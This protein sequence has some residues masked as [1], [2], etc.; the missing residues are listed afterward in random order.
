MNIQLIPRVCSALSDQVNCEKAIDA[1][2]ADTSPD[3]CT[4][5]LIGKAIAN[6]EPMVVAK[7]LYGFGK[8]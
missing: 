2:G 5:K 4:A 7:S 3:A 8:G 1:C 6:P